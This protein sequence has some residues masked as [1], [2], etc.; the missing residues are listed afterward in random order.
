MPDPIAATHAA[1][2]A[3]AAT[4]AL[5]A[6]PS[7]LHAQKADLIEEYA[8][9]ASGLRNMGGGNYQFN[10]KTPT[11]YVGSCK[12]IGLDF[13]GGYVEVALANFNFKN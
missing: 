1:A 5:L 8:S 9:G 11:N 12:N 10:W 4:L 6:I 7:A 2:A 3:A 13:R